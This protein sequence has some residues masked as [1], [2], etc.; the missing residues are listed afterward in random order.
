MRTLDGIKNS[1]YFQVKA[2]AFTQCIFWLWQ[3]VLAVVVNNPKGITVQRMV[4]Q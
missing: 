2:A 3:G 4:D 1:L